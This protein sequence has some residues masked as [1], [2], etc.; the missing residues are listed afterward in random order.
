M[1]LLVK[2]LVIHTHHHIFVI[3]DD[4]K[5]P[6][7]LTYIQKPQENEFVPPHVQFNCVQINIKYTMMTMFS[8]TKRAH[9]YDVR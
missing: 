4:P 5:C 9:E 7:M 6:H 3:G 1:I 2:V 8:G